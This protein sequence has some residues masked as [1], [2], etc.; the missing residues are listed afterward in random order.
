M[1]LPPLFTEDPWPA[2]ERRLMAH[3]LPVPAGEIGDPVAVFVLMKTG[4]R[5]M[6]RSVDEKRGRLGSQ[7]QFCLIYCVIDRKY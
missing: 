3:V 4:D 7:W 6:K 1:L 2:H 5:L